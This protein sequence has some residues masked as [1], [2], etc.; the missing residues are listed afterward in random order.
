[1]DRPGERAMSLV[2]AAVTPSGGPLWAWKTRSHSVEIR[3]RC[4]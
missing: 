4:D 3:L 1:M 2:W